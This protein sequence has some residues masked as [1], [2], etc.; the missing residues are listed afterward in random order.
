[1][2]GFKFYFWVE[3]ESSDMSA[4]DCHK[5]HYCKACPTTD[6]RLIFCQSAGQNLPD[7]TGVSDLGVS[8]PSTLGV[9]D[10]LTWDY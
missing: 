4:M 9:K 3:R 5:C 8:G 7:S 1:M 10:L 2:K 6:L